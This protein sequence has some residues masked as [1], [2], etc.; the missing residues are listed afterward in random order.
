MNKIP[1]LK[2]IFLFFIFSFLFF[3]SANAAELKITSSVS[4]VGVGQ[5]FYVD[6]MLD[7]EGSDIN[8]AQGTINFPSD[9]LKF[10]SLND[11]DSIITFWAEKPA[12]KDSMVFFSGVIPGGFK[13]V[14][15]P[16]YQGTRPGKILRLYFIVKDNGNAFIKISDAKVLLNDGKGTEADLKISNF[17]FLVLK[18][19]EFPLG[20]SVSK[21]GPS[22]KDTESPEDFR[23]E[24]TSDPDL[25]SG[26][27]VL[28][29]TAKDKGSGIDHYEIQETRDKT[30][31]INKG[32]WDKAESPYLLKDQKLKSY[33]YVKAVDKAGN[34]RVVYLP[35]PYIP[36][37]KKP[38]V[39]ILLGLAILISVIIV[40]RWLLKKFKTKNAK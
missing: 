18:E 26:K 27:H 4:E 23:P 24:I 5:K 20:N 17:Q 30:Q 8:A 38:L 6:L 7:T 12:Y 33:I 3:T 10:D 28:V 29:W 14:L 1:K 22:S 31:D 15:S 39:D 35:P 37:Y 11:G 34:M 32:K 2:I 16:Y 21:Q 40:V 19:T 13:G 25:F 36:W 9:I